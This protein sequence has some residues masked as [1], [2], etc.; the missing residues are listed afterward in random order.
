VDQA[1]I[2]G[3]GVVAEKRFRDD[4]PRSLAATSR[5]AGTMPRGV[6]VSWMDE[7]YDHPPVWL[8][9]GA[10]SRFWDI[11]GHE[12]V[13]MYGADMSAFCGHAPAPVVRAVS[14]GIAAG[15]G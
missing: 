12:Y 14:M 11:E 9:C 5:A 6:P 4:R 15:H 13:E 7:L 10:G 3:L 1:R 8:S 2:Q